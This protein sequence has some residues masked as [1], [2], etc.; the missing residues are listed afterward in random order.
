MPPKSPGEDENSQIA[1]YY[2]YAYP[3]YPEGTGDDGWSLVEILG[4]AR[5]RWEIIATSIVIGTVAA[6]VWGYHQPITYSATAQILIEPEH[7][8]VDL[9]S[10]VDAVGSDAGA[11][12]TQLNLL[13]SSGFL[14]GFVSRDQVA[15]VSEAHAL[16]QLQLMKDAVDQG[17][18]ATNTAFAA[19]A[20]ANPAGLSLSRVIADRAAGIQRGLKVV[21]QGRS[22]IIDIIYTSTDPEE[23]A[24]T[25]NDLASYYISDEAERRR[26][27]TGDASRF[28]EDRLEQLEGEL[29]DAEEAV[30]R[31]RI[32]NPTS[33]DND[34]NI[35]DE[36]LSDLV[37]ILIR[38]RAERKEKEA[39]LAFIK[40]LRRNGANIDSLTEV[41]RSPHMASLWEEES[42]L[43]KAEAEL[44]LDFGENHPRIIALNEERAELE[45][46]V[47]LETD[48]IVANVANELQVLRERE[49]S[50]DQDMDNLSEL[51]NE[52]D[53]STDHA[54]IQLRLLEGK[55]ETS[56]RI[57]EDFL[58]RFKETRE[59][60]AIV[61]ANTRMV[62]SAKTPTVPSSSSPL[63]LALLGLVGSSAVGFGLA[64]L[65]D[66]TDR[67]LRNAKEIAQSLKINFLGS[68]PHLSEK[69]RDQRRFH[70]YLKRKRASRFAESIRSVY[71]QLMITSESESSPKVVLVTSTVPNE[72]KTTF[73][74]SLSTMLALD[75]KKTLLLDLDFRNPSVYSLLDLDDDEDDDSDNGN[76]SN[77]EAFLRSQ[78]DDAS[79]SIVEMKFGCHVLGLESAAKD[80][81]KLLR[82]SRLSDMLKTMRDRYDLII[83]DGP[84][85]LGLSDIKA[86]LA[87]VDSLVFIAR[88]NSTNA[89]IAAE[90]V[91]ELQRCK[92]QIAGAV[93]TQVNLKKQARYGYA[94]SGH[95]PGTDNSYYRN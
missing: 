90:A 64:F 85:S 70:E 55:A 45:D 23:A 95:Y 4:L 59:Q 36:R 19:D 5:R 51:A 39:R 78:D 2:K 46:R 69:E 47:R 43:R 24:Q 42:R 44:R 88:W 28:L 92:A 10:V 73:A 76:K 35:T 58:V 53:R 9:D 81:G 38:T 17:S 32:E 41:L 21:Q 12:E 14:E 49:R 79:P 80:P 7:R 86:L 66:R 67:K 61:Q 84:P 68:V 1:A 91:Q 52:A 74:T 13:K 15:E 77:F 29:L 87:V 60:E 72:G 34:T 8:V 94:G 65:R 54:G 3:P 20:G 6:T 56:R 50:L 22:F 27:I 82:S 62:A 48:R 18:K 89:D 40:Q 37:S 63:R 71:T 25:A 75:E 93:L 33:V 57:Y 26:T 16:S 31:Y 30:H 11:I 83:I